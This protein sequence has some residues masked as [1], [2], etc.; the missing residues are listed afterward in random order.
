MDSY[1][2]TSLEFEHISSVA[3][4][5]RDMTSL[6]VSGLV[7]LVKLGAQ[8]PAL[9]GP[10]SV[11][12]GQLVY[13]ND[14]ALL[15]SE[16]GFKA[17]HTPDVRLRIFLD[18]MDPILPARPGMVE[19]NGGFHVTAHTATFGADVTMAGSPKS[20][21]F[22][23]A[24]GVQIRRDV[25]NLLGCQ[26]FDQDFAGDAIFL[27]R[28]HCTFLEK[29]TYARDAGASGVIVVNTDDTSINPSATSDEVAAAG[30]LHD[31]ALVLLSHTAGKNIAAMLDASG[32]FGYG[33]VLFSIDP[34]G[35]S[36]QPKAGGNKH[37]QGGQ[38][39]HVLHINGHPLLNTRLLV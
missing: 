35:W 27:W 34:E 9:V 24:E 22:G 3:W 21:V 5:E 16:D 1:S 13:I 31:V 29:L 8:F 18:T 7:C 14:T 37:D 28:G 19:L 2:R 10:H 15:L 11:R 38:T 17:P 30:E 39:P 6:N 4:M 12:T 32:L 23:R 25:T 26:P 33:N 36:S 20:L